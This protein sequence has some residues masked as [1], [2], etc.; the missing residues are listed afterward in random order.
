M[1][2]KS[3]SNNKSTEAEKPL[4]SVEECHSIATQLRGYAQA[5]MSTHL[6]DFYNTEKCWR[7]L[8]E[9]LLKQS[10]QAVM[11]FAPFANSWLRLLHHYIETALWCSVFN[12]N[13]FVLDDKKAM[14]M[15][16]EALKGYREVALKLDV[17]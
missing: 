10:N 13:R 5:Q 1:S 11:D 9:F 4:K 6:L 12:S 15:A 16:D 17:L 14:S 7:E 8:T 2:N 3:K